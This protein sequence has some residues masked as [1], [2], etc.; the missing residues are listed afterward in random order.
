MSETEQ[1]NKIIESVKNEL[2]KQ[3]YIYKEGGRKFIDT[4][5][6]PQNPKHREKEITQMSK[7]IIEFILNG[8]SGSLLIYGNSGTGKTMSFK[9]AMKV[10]KA[11][12]EEL[13]KKDFRVL[14]ITAK[15]TDITP[16]MSE[17]CRELDIKAPSRGIS[18]KDY[19][20]LIRQ[21]LEQTYVHICIDEFDNLLLSRT[22][23]KAEDLIYY[24]TRTEKLS[25]TIIT[26]RINL[27][28][29]IQDARVFSS[30]NTLN[31]INFGDYGSEQCYEILL[32]RTN[33]AFNSNFIPDKVLQTLSKHISIEGGDI[34]KGLSVLGLCA[35]YAEDCSVF[36]ITPE[37]IK[38]IIEKYDILKDGENLRKISISGQLILAS[39]YSLLLT[40][41]ND[42]LD[43]KDIFAKQDYFRS[44]LAMPGISR[45]SHSVYLTKLS[46]S[47][48][49]STTRNSKGG[50]EGT[51]MLITLRYP[52][53]AIKYMLHEEI[54]LQN[55][56]EEINGELKS[57]QKGR[58]WW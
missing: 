7:Q 20:N 52:R 46:T 8:V 25:L 53:D 31:T 24:F 17:I 13:N 9:V 49:I 38:D 2:E 54:E 19:I 18:F 34:R 36:S 27:A 33:M 1:I 41:K 55:I 21:K 14:F 50:R 51:T 29:E 30:L 32:E 16:L 15:G 3:K 40:N 28:K 11:Y 5:Y 35:K 37:I 58:I 26:N 12:M 6:I 23:D 44:I 39:M 56:S 48:I 42:K 10:T 4:E 43:S 45:E 57:I 22:K 47:G